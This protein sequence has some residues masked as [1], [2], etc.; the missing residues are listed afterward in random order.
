MA[1]IVMNNSKV[2]GSVVVNGENIDI[3]PNESIEVSGRPSCQTYNIKII[4]HVISESA[5]KSETVPQPSKPQGD[6][7]NNTGESTNG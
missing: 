2:L 7:K 6:G 3:S 1:Y 4:E 5:K